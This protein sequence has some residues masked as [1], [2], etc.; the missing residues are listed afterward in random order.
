MNFLEIIFE[1]LRRDGEEPV[2]QEIRD[3]K[4]DSVSGRE[5]LAL[6]QTAR[7]FLR[8]AGLHKRDRC[9]LLAPNSI[10]WA[11][12]D[13]ALMAEGVV[14]IPLYARQAPAEL[15]GMIK[16]G[17]PSLV[18]CGDE[19]LLDAVKNHLSEAT[20]LVTLETVFANISAS[21]GNRA[22]ENPTPLAGD[23]PVTI[24]Y[25]SGT[26]GEPKGVVLIVRNLNH[27]LPCT[28]DRLD[29]LMGPRQEPDRVF[30][31]LPLN[32]AGSWIILL[33]CLSRHSVVALS[34]DLTKLGDELKLAAPNYFL[35]VPTLLERVRA[36]IEE[37]I[38]QRSSMAASLFDKARKAWL[39]LHHEEAKP[40]DPIWIAVA[41]AFMFPSI[42][43]SLGPNL[44][45]LICGSAPLAIETQLFYAMLGV[46][47]LQGY[48][49]TETTA[50][51]TLDDPHAVEPGRVGLAIPEVQMLLGEN[52]EI[53][54][55]G[56]NVFSGYWNKPEATARILQDGWFHTG[57]QG[58]VNATG[59]WRIIGRLKEL[60][61]LN[62]GH[63]IA[64]EPIEDKLLRSLPGAQQ[65][66]LYGNDR[67]YPV[68]LVSIAASN[69]LTRE[70]IE[71]AVAQANAGLPHY[72]QIRNFYFGPN[73]FTIENGLLT[74]NGKLKRSMIAAHF[75]E[76]IEDMY[77]KP[78]S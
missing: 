56:P 1:R 73:L 76:A 18:C 29:R 22:L 65:V 41:N 11:A 30:H 62:S 25:T 64:P 47:V 74:A 45:A 68:A 53:L 60:I 48:G 33:T 36:K 58:E 40:M 78:Q 31:Y 5:F 55:R 67:S 43:K 59:N 8:Q 72:K 49:L 61:I 66:M 50:L 19:I 70:Q 21:S 3:G 35:N 16:D 52:Q 9:A 54:V 2:L 14:V 23:D 38:K 69:A 75:H 63:N 10:R 7:E 71:T 39:R 77:R 28:N 15:A 12:L 46:P 17:S 42:R 6:I 51:C 37:Q 24:I 32:F 44:K 27:M 26:S 4:I 57:D 34:T 13:L 20:P